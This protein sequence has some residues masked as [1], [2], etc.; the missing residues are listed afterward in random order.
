MTAMPEIRY[1]C[2]RC[3]AEASAAVQ[4]VTPSA[5][6]AGPPD[7]IML[8]IGSDLTSAPKHLCKSCGEIFTAFLN[9]RKQ[10]SLPHER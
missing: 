2:D 9:E 3:N 8:V 1:Q 10:R 7:W 6:M 5:R 4:N